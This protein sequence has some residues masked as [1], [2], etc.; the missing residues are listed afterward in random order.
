MQATTGIFDYGVHYR[1]AE[2]KS[3]SIMIAESPPFLVAETPAGMF[4]FECSMTIDGP[5]KHERLWSL[6]DPLTRD[7]K[8]AV[9][10]NR[11]AEVLREKDIKQLLEPG[12]VG[13]T[14]ELLVSDTR[15]GKIVEQRPPEKSKSFVRQFLELFWIMGLTI[16]ENTMYQLRDMS[17]VLHNIPDTLQIM[18]VNAPIAVDTWGIQVGIDTG[19]PHAPTINDYALVTKILHDAAP[20]TAGRM[21][22]SNTTFGAPASNPTTS[23]F[24]ITRNFAN[25]SGGA[26]T[27]MELGLVAK[28]TRYSATIYYFLEI[29]DVIGGG[30]LVNNGQTL[31]INY[32]PQCVI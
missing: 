29:R 2:I 13:A 15:T 10:L 5:D 27:V 8:R 22:Y 25:A 12:E 1:V 32:R 3:K 11:A 16:G 14:F 30:I 20:P 21:Q 26:I 7:V 24:T 6:V 23:Q 4:Y 31:T 28:G 18:A 9:E 17:N 19:G